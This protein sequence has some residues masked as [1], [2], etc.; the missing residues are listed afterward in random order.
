MNTAKID[1]CNEL[2]FSMTKGTTWSWDVFVQSTKNKIQTLVNLTNYTARMDIKNSDGVLLYRLSSTLAPGQ[3]TLTIMP[4][5]GK[6][7]MNIP[8]ADSA[9]FPE[10]CYIYDLMIS[11]ST[12]QVYQ[13]LKGN[14]TVHST[15]TDL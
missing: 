1:S 3:G 12:S 7:T 6:I 2:S 11:S 8:I 13:I 10:G 4:L 5:D 14:F 9:A 15:V